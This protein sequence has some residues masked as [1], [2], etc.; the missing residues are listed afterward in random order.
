MCQRA[1]CKTEPHIYQHERYPRSKKEP[2]DRTGIRCL[3]CSV[4]VE[5]PNDREVLHIVPR[6]EQREAHQGTLRHAG[7]VAEVN[8]SDGDEYELERI[9]PASLP[10]ARCYL[11][12]VHKGD[13][14]GHNEPSASEP[15]ESFCRNA[16]SATLIEIRD[17]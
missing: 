4:E 1:E 6:F 13:G 14:N 16:R 5:H 2:N 12:D 11:E 9:W 17:V 15:N 8:K 10:D 7:R 3:S